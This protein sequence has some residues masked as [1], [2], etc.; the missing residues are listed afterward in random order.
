MYCSGGGG[1][2]P[3]GGFERRGG[4]GGRGEGGYERQGGSFDRREGACSS[5]QQVW[6]LVHGSIV[7]A[8]L[9]HG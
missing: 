6:N 7:S 2:A 9:T 5:V 3:R 8:G 4:Y 1:Y